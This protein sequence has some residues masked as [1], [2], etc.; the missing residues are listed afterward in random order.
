IMAGH[1]VKNI[2]LPPFFIEQIRPPTPAAIHV[3]LMVE[4]PTAFIEAVANAGADYIFPHA[5]T[6]HR[7]AF[8]VINLFRS[9]GTKPGVV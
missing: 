9:L 3:H 8:R 7:D 5:E 6:I 4:Q 2:P 1:Y